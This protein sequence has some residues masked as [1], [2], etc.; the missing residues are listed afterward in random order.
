MRTIA[1]A[2]AAGALLAATQANAG[3][4]P[5]NSLTGAGTGL[6]DTVAVRVYVHEGHRYCFYFNGWHGPGW[7]RCGF[8]LRRGFGWGGVYGWNDWSYGPYERRF[9][10]RVHRGERFGYGEEREGRGRVGVES[11]STRTRDSVETRSRTRST[12]GAGAE[13]NT[14]VNRS[15]TGRGP[16]VDVESH[17]GAKIQGGEKVQRGTTG[18][19]NVRG[20]GERGSGDGDQGEQKRQ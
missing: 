12:T 13:S 11:G 1:L 17:G 9:H 10:V 3:S 15:T 16:G 19:T 2:V 18:S 7:Y 20:G 4:F 14:R 6:V 8:A 5:V